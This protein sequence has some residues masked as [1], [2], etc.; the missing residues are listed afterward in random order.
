VISTYYKEKTGKWKKELSARYT[1]QIFSDATLRQRI[2]FYSICELSEL[3]LRL[4]D[5]DFAALHNKATDDFFSL[6]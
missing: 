6:Q 4:Y 5:T 3:F 1:D 2:F